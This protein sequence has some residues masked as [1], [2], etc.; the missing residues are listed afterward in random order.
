MENLGV[1]AFTMALSALAVA[2]M[3]LVYVHGR[4]N[5]L[6]KKLKEF[7]VIPS[8]FDSIP[9]GDQ[10]R[11]FAR[12]AEEFSSISGLEKKSPSQD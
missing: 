9:K 2:I 5:N 7:D 10:A 12:I 3:G 8:E 1:V 11:F 4:L 6:E